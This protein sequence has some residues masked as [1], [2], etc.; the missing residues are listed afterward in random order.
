MSNVLVFQMQTIMHHNGSGAAAYSSRLKRREVHR[1]ITLHPVKDHRHMY[2]LHSH[3]INL[4]VAELRER[5]LLLR[6]ELRSL[7][8]DRDRDEWAGEDGALVYEFISR[9]VYSHDHDNP[10]RRIET[11]LKE[12]LDDLI[13]EVMDIMNAP[14]R[15][16]GRVIEFTELL[17]G[18]RQRHPLL[19]VRSVL[20]L[21]LRYRRYRGRKLTAA[22]RRHA[23]VVQRFTG[24]EIRELDVGE[25]ELVD[26]GTRAGLLPDVREAVHSLSRLMWGPRGR[27]LR[28]LL[29]LSGRLDQL[30][31]FL[32]DYERVVLLGDEPGT[33][34]VLLHLDE[35]GDHARAVALLA[36]LQARH[37]ARPDAVR[38]TKLPDAEF[39]RGAALTRGLEDCAE[40]DLVFFID[41]DV[42][43][44]AEG[45]RAARA[46]AAHGRVYFPIVFSEYDPVVVESR[47][48]NAPPGE[49]W[50]PSEREEE[51]AG[52]VSAAEGHFRRYGF[53]LAAGE[54]RALLAAGGFDLKLRGWGLED[55]R[56]YEALLRAPWPMVV[57]AP[58]PHLRHRHHPA[59][60]APPGPSPVDEDGAAQLR[61]CAGSRASSFA[62]ERHL[63]TYL[64]NHL[65]YVE[66]KTSAV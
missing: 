66:A 42:E 47:E 3:F 46:H 60:C 27:P 55:V 59:A 63:H 48:F 45:L 29:P 30:R 54:K 50:S 19:G 31:R 11:P 10:K 13:R 33:L 7:A 18:Y 64:L 20:D 12:A 32:R 1:A 22:V 15:E 53:G 61:M 62:S 17:Y 21:L 24:T 9:A 39:S 44:T 16:R 40:T 28:L 56:L 35:R 57:R 41:V 65:E 23:Y 26:Y 58:A 37:P 5:Q 8:G 36:E 34:T 4:R 51:R 6:R 38:L 14:S 52:T 43:F 25:E 2:R 49:S